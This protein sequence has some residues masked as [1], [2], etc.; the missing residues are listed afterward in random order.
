MQGRRAGGKIVGAELVA[1]TTMQ[2]AQGSKFWLGWSWAQTW[3]GFK[4]VWEGQ[5]R[6][7]ASWAQQRRGRRR[8]QVA[9]R[10][11]VELSWGGVLCAAGLWLELGCLCSRAG[12]QEGQPHHEKKVKELQDSMMFCMLPTTAQ[13]ATTSM[14]TPTTFIRA[15]I[16]RDGLSTT[17]NM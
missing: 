15:T 7:G 5:G 11:T 6:T 9:A 1:L 3:V 8:R 13:S 14:H 16:G 2:R 17:A 12:W 4:A 10:P